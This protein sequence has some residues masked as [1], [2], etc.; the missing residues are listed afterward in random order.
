MSGP[1]SPRTPAWRLFGVLV[2]AVV[3]PH[4][5]GGPATAQ[6]DPKAKDGALK[7]LT[8]GVKY[9]DLKVGAGESC[10]EGAKVKV[11]Y[12]GWLADG[13]VFD[14]SRNGQAAEFPLDGLIVGWQ[15]GIPGM[16]VGGVR[17]LVIAPEKG[18]GERATGKIPANSTLTFEIELLGFSGG[19]E[20]VK[21]R[22][23]RSPVP[24]ELTKLFDGTLPTA[25][26]PKLKAVGKDGLLVR[27]L[28][29]GDGPEVK[30]GAQ[31]V[32]DYIGWLKTDGTVFD[33]SFKRP[34]PFP[35]DLAGGLI[36]GWMQGVPGMKVGGIRKLVIP[37]ELAY[38]ER[39]S[40]PVI[41]PNATLVFEVEV[42]GTR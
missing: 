23:R 39:G 14:S 25:D 26:D 37:P 18:Y 16:K 30:A 2:F 31:V 20:K 3:G 41:P 33:S 40:P 24:K 38:G 32:V 29:V 17:K 8:D 11:H 34:E 12:T 21:A 1:V 13:T 28:K 4:F 42:L 27:D 9:R 22:P 36:R 15:E 35:G 5:F 10:P 19:S 7:E 6:P